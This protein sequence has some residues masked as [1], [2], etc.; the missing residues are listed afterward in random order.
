MKGEILHQV[1]RI[2]KNV[3]RNRGRNFAIM[4]VLT[5]SFM[6][7][8]LM[9]N[10]YVLSNSQIEYAKQN[11]GTKLTLQ[12]SQDY[13]EQFFGGEGKKGSEQYSQNP[14]LFSENITPDILSGKH[15]IRAE[16]I[17][18]GEAQVE[19]MVSPMQQFFEQQGKFSEVQEGGKGEAIDIE[20]KETA[21]LEERYYWPLPVIGVTNLEGL[22]EFENGRLELV[23]GEPFREY[24]VDKNICVVSKDFADANNLTVGSDL[25]INGYTLNI[26]GTFENVNLGEE[27][28]DAEMKVSSLDNI[29]VPLRT[30]RVLLS[31]EEDELASVIF[32][33]DSYDNVDTVIQQT[34]STIREYGLAEKLSITSNAAQF[35]NTVSS[36]ES[37]KDV[38]LIGLLS[39]F[40]AGFII[41]LSSMFVS[42]RGR[43]REIGTMKAIGFSNSGIIK[44]FL[45]ESLTICVIALVIGLILISVAN[46]FLVQNFVFE[47]AERSSD[48][49]QNW[50]AWE[51]N[52]LAAAPDI[53]H[54]WQTS[55]DYRSI[56]YAFLASIL[57]CLIGTG[58]P[59][60]LIARLKPA[61]VIRFE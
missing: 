5:I 41:I 39:A 34:E 35:E 52:Q 61:D 24:D 18:T 1:L 30:A 36:I 40:G 45:I 13:L 37:V 8:I 59:A 6:L 23:E 2:I 7:G 20:Q 60:I 16:R 19:D 14:Y 4:A 10:S 48:Q 51:A 11:L 22:P 29:Y 50:E 44:Q 56:L 25:T 21:D 46:D 27:T 28:S 9:L 54:N 47:L 42:V 55:M 57:V 53:T 58:I 32:T 26:K 49:P 43:A 15:I 3:F 12:V 31:L 17:V 33:V 38:S